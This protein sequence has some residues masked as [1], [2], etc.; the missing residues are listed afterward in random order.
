MKRFFRSAILLAVLSC[1]IPAVLLVSLTSVEA[2]GKARKVKATCSNNPAKT[3]AKKGAIIKVIEDYAETCLIKCLPRCGSYRLTKNEE[4]V[5]T[6]TANLEI[7]VTGP[8]TA[9]CSCEVEI[10]E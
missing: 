6:E 7:W 2:Q 9:A 5:V 4:M 10:R 3:H 1:L 8:A